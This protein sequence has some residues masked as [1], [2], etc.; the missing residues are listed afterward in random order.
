MPDICH[1]AGE[2]RPGVPP[3]GS[4]IIQY[5]ARALGCRGTR[6]IAPRRIVVDAVGRIGHHQ[7]RRDKRF[8][9]SR[10]DRMRT[11][12]RVPFQFLLVNATDI[13]VLNC[14]YLK[15]IFFQ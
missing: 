11:N 15:Y 8:S 7:V 1:I 10:A 4:F 9:D 3:V 12:C 2:E 5:L 14:L 13:E 6:F